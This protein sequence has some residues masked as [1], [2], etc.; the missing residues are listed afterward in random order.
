MPSLTENDEYF[1]QVENMAALAKVYPQSHDPL[2][3]PYWATEEQVKGL[4]PMIIS[5]NELD[6]LRDEGLQFARKCARA[7]NNVYSKVIGGTCHG[8]DMMCEGL[9][10]QIYHGSLRE[11]VGF[12]NEV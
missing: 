2:A 4:P 9:A 11:I 3:W 6:P 12:A 10:P 5:V 1:L 7:G 8:T